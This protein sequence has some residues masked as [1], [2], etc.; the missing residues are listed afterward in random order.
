MYGIKRDRQNFHRATP[1]STI[2]VN[3]DAHLSVRA[4]DGKLKASSEASVVPV[5]SADRCLAF[6]LWREH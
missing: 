4:Y 6:V 2:V 5:E 1:L 3:N